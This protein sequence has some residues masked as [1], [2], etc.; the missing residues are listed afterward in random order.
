LKEIAILNDF[1][2]PG[3]I[4]TVTIL[5]ENMREKLNREMKHFIRSIHPRIFDMRLTVRVGAKIRYGAR[6]II[7][8]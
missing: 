8:N 4:H 3:P 1:V 7:I 2:T 6:I 5:P